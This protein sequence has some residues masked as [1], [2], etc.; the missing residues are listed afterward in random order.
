MNIEV[1]NPVRSLT[2]AGGE[3][4]VQELNWR[5]GMTFLGMVSKHAGE[6]IGGDLQK[7]EIDFAKLPALIG[8]V[9]ELGDFLLTK[10]TGRKQEEIDAL[11]F[12]EALEVMEAA[13]E[14]NLSEELLQRGKSV[15][16]RVGAAFGVKKTKA[17]E[18]S[19]APSIS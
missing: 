15:A 10:A 16:G 13:I 3:W 14:L 19:P 5:D 12:Q 7:I 18:T 6:I 4:T 8:N 17:P 1:L 2:I 11:R 9:K